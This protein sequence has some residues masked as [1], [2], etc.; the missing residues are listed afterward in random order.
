MVRVVLTVADA[1]G[2][3]Y[4]TFVHPEI[5]APARSSASHSTTPTGRTSRAEAFIGR[6]IFTTDSGAAA[7]TR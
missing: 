6:V 2:P 3:A 1:I 4:W 7:L 5:L